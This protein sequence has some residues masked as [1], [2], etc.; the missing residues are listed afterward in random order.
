M[1]GVAGVLDLE[2]W[3]RVDSRHRE[4]AMELLTREANAAVEG[5][6]AAG[7][8]EIVV[9]DTHGGGGRGVIS[10]LLHPAAELACRSPRGSVRY[11]NT[12]PFDV[13]AF[14]GQYP[15]AGTVGGHLCHTQG[16]GVRDM[17]INGV[18]VGDFGELVLCAGELGI[19]CIF[20]SGC[21]ALARE[22]ADLV[23]GIGTVAV[24]RGLQTDPG[25]SLPFAAYM[26][27]NIAAI[28]LSPEEARKRIRVGAQRALERA[29]KEDFGLVKLPPPYH[30]VRV[31]RSDETHGPRVLRK[32]HPTSVIALLNSPGVW[33]ELDAD[34][35]KLV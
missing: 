28:H 30:S 20:A 29:R 33:E 15:K 19:R 4:Q 25:H 26:N 32:S 27:H 8:K 9:V 10:S 3:C 31:F 1:E 14:V 12:R 5:F 17:T 24:K 6:L 35:M 7:A 23:P 21:E 2:N 18:S 13:A 34:P 16:H 22:A 11:I